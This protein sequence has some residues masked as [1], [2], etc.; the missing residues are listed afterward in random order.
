MTPDENAQLTDVSPGA[1]MNRLWRSY[2]LPAIRSPRLLAGGRPERVRLLGESYVAFRADDGRVGVFAEACLHR[3]ASLALARNENCALRCLYH[4][5]TFSVGG[6][7]LETPNDPSPAFRKSVRL[8]HVPVREAGGMV[9]VYLG[10]GAAPR[11]ADFVFNRLPASHV[12]ARAAVVRSNWLQGLEGTVDPAHVAILH[13]DITRSAASLATLHLL[14]EAPPRFATEARP[15]GMSVAA[16]RALGDG[17][18]Y[19]RVTEWVAPGF[20]LIP[21]G[22]DEPQQCIATIPIDNHHTLQWNIFFHYTRPLAPEER[23]IMRLGTG[24]DDDSIYEPPEGQPYWGQDREAM[25]RG[26]FSGLPG[27]IVEDFVIAESMGPVVDREAE[28]LCA[29]DLGVVRLRRLLKDALARLLAGETAPGLA[30]D[31]DYSAIRSTAGIF[32][33]DADW[34]TLGS[35]PGKLAAAE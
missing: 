7:V 2:W 20:A 33:A 21:Y 28:Q 1:P 6:E 3:R 17:R 10:A 5:W 15:W 19:V 25:R 13:Q 31:C 35:A 27:V 22:P 12:W 26:S 4:G 14:P 30:E 8:R 34:R 24:L 18:S 16:L 29:A 23:E 9:W 32:A 11:F